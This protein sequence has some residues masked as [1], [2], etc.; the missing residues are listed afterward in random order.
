M[1][2]QK[3]MYNKKQQ[4][5]SEITFCNSNISVDLTS[6]DHR[7]AYQDLGLLVDTFVP[8]KTTKKGANRFASFR[9]EVVANMEALSI[10][11]KNI[12]LGGLWISASL[13]KY[14]Q[15]GNKVVYHPPLSTDVS[16]SPPTNT[17]LTR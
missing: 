11:S 5:F 10:S 17:P 7:K 12:K 4:V 2:N 6:M 8:K 16:S 13:A 14:V 1:N 9:Y 3:K 15:F